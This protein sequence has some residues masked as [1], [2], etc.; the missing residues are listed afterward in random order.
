VGM[1]EGGGT[2]KFAQLARFQLDLGFTFL[3]RVFRD[4]LV[5][6]NPS[7]NLTA[8]LK[9]MLESMS[10][11]QLFSPNA[12]TAALAFAQ[13]DNLELRFSAS[14]F[15]LRSVEYGSEMRYLPAAFRNLRP[16]VENEAYRQAVVDEVL[17]CAEQVGKRSGD[18]LSSLP[19]DIQVFL[20][21][22]AVWKGRHAANPSATANLNELL[23]EF[24]ADPISSDAFEAPVEMKLHVT[25]KELQ[26]VFSPPQDIDI[27]M[28]H[29]T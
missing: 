1:L 12:I 23:L 9:S 3:Q 24:E 17:R 18:E 21:K 11:H 8:L 22:L 25:L 4:N 29:R 28:D 15:L 6:S 13:S 10:S 20:Q 14:Q 7:S 27:G 5:E 16:L 19:S 2:G 26:E